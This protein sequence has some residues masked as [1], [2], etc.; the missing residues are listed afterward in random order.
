MV[1]RLGLENFLVQRVRLVLLI[2]AEVSAKATTEFMHFW[3]EGY[4]FSGADAVMTFVRSEGV[5]VTMLMGEEKITRC[6]LH[7]LSRQGA[8]SL[9]G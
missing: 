5:L 6:W 3:N 1:F 9:L 4:A 7:A 2:D 8:W